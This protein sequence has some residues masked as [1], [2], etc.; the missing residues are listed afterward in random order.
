MSSSLAATHPVRGL[1]RLGVRLP[2]VL[3]RVHLGRLLGERFLML[4]HIGR[5]S[6]KP[7]QTVLEVVD[8]DRA[9]DAYVVTSGWGEKSDW[10][11]NVLKTPHVV[12]HVGRQR[13]EVRAERL[14]VDEAERWL[15]NYAQRHPRTFRELAKFMTGESLRGTREDC[16]RVAE[17]VPV[18]AFRPT[19]R[20]E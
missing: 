19:K 17:S 6:G 18:V 3:Y 12:I 16:R 11:Q 8:Y 9:T 10:F 5:K 1:L 7:H 20:S 14:S 4:T 13:L 15:L 2:L